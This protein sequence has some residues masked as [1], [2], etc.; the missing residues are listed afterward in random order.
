MRTLALILAAL[1]LTGCAHRD[2]RDRSWD[3][4]PGTQLFQQMPNWDGEAVRVC[5]KITT[6]C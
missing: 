6:L 2:Y 3:P 5:G 4:Q 1:A